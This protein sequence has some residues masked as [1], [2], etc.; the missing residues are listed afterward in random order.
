MPYD[1]LTDVQKEA[2]VNSDADTI[3]LSTL[4][5][6]H[7]SFS[8]S[9]K[10]VRDSVVL[11]GAKIESGAPEAP[12]AT[13]DFQPFWFDFVPPEIDG[14]PD[15]TFNITVVNAGGAI[16]P[17]LESATETIVPIGV[18]Y[19][20]YLYDSLNGGLL[21]S[22]QPSADPFYLEAFTAE[23]QGNTAIFKIIMTPIGNRSFP[24]FTYTPEDFPGLLTL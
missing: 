15:P 17:Y 20:T 18:V 5:I 9:L 24:S 13:V 1:N 2:Y 16:T 3:T 23:V 19:R 4:E 10:I 21:N 7:P 22:G 11:S 6:Y 8:S 14:D 12:G